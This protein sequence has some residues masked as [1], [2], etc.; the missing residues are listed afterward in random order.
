M[1]NTV[2][3][4]VCEP[5]RRPWSQLGCWVGPGKKGRPCYHGLTTTT[6]IRWDCYTFG[7]YDEVHAKVVPRP[8]M[9]AVGTPIAPP[10]DSH[11]REHVRSSSSMRWNL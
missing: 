1:K 8:A 2:L 5:L 7:C 3:V 11:P 10:K 6:T 9:L 4:D